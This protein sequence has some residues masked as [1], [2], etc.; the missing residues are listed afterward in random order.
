METIAESGEKGKRQ[1]KKDELCR[2][3][4]WAAANSLAFSH[5]TAL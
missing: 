5:S 3:K 1:Q 4:P 2:K